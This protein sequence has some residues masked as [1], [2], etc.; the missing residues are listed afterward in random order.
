MIT[1]R[2]GICL[3]PGESRGCPLAKG[4][5]NLQFPQTQDHS[6]RFPTLREYPPGFSP[7]EGHYQPLE[8]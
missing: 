6:G 8:L 5:F 7:G 4:A 2:S 3:I 1:H